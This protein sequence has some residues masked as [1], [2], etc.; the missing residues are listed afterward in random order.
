MI[1]KENNFINEKFVN[2]Y[3]DNRKEYIYER[4]SFMKCGFCLKCYRI[5]FLIIKIYVEKYFCKFINYGV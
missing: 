5:R 3:W 4:F 2:L 1:V